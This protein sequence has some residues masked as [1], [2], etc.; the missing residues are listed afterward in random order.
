MYD[1]FGEW[2]GEQPT[3]QPSDM[4]DPYREDVGSPV[5]SDNP[6][7]VVPTDVVMQGNQNVNGTNGKWENLLQQGV[8]GFFNYAIARD[9]AKN[10]I[11]RS[12][13][14]PAY[15]G[16]NGRIYGSTPEPVRKPAGNAAAQNAGMLPLIAIA[17][18]GLYLAG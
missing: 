17:G 14:A 2:L 10:G 4:I 18:I 5:V 9:S 3:D 12:N 7:G 13:A 16:S 6:A 11:T 8:S 15:R 1:A